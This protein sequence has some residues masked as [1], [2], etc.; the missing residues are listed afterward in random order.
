MAAIQNG[1]LTI[2]P[3][4][5]QTILASA[6]TP[7]PP[8]AVAVVHGSNNANLLSCGLCGQGIV[9][10]SEPSPTRTGYLSRANGTQFNT[11]SS[12]IFRKSSV[13]TSPSAPPSPPP[14]HDTSSLPAQI[15]IFRLSDSPAFPSALPLCVSGWCLA[16]LRATCTLWSFLRTNILEKIWEEAAQSPLVPPPRRAIEGATFDKPPVPPRRKTKNS[17]FWGVASS[18][19]LDRVPG[20]GEIDKDKR[21]E[22]EPEKRRFVAPPLRTSSPG[23][24]SLGPPPPLPSRNRSRPR[25]PVPADSG[26][27][28]RRSSV[29]NSSAR[30]SQSSASD[31]RKSPVTWKPEGSPTLSGL[32]V[33][34]PEDDLPNECFLTPFED[35]TTPETAS[36]SAEPPASVALPGSPAATSVPL[37]EETNETPNEPEGP[38]PESKLAEPTVAQSASSNSEYVEPRPQTPPAVNSERSEPVSPPSRTGSPGAPPLPRRAAARR[39]VPP[40]PLVPPEPAAEAPAA[41]VST[42]EVVKQPDGHHTEETEA[43]PEPDVKVDI[44]SPVVVAPETDPPPPSSEERGDLPEANTEKEE[45]GQADVLP[46]AESTES[47]VQEQETSGAE[48]E[49]VDVAVE[50]VEPNGDQSDEQQRPQSESQPTEP[51]LESQ[52]ES[53]PERPHSVD[54]STPHGDDATI[55]NSA[56]G[57]DT[58]TTPNDADAGPERPSGLEKEK[59]KMAEVEAEVEEKEKEKEKE[60][61]AT[62]VTGKARQPP[63]PPPRHPHPPARSTERRVLSDLTSSMGK[64]DTGKSPATAEPVYALDGMPYVGDATWE[65]RTWKELTRLREDMFWARLG[66]AQ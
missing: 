39:R 50:A 33:S 5:T 51:K 65:E 64:L 2:E 41:D 12:S 62:P 61:P 55:E 23:P 35:L 53:Q 15:Y 10:H 11:W 8:L 44:P 13:T 63:R 36:V 4:A 47:A 37:P 66:S 40:P 52:P 32:L 49:I 1:Q 56:E 25:T 58:T 30:G 9:P 18:F 54:S 45:G 16:R 29:T 6:A 24:S 34:S 27:E 20:W 48:A 43:R 7:Q 59:M 60:E 26:A 31:R 46:V 21:T 19:G 3:I 28:G 57:A 42:T 17:S 14:Y 22:L 38:H